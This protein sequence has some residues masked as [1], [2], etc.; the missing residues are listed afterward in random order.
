MLIN[1]VRIY[2]FQTEEQRLKVLQLILKNEPTADNVEIATLAKHTEGFSGSDLQE[3]CRNASIYRIR[4]YL[5][6]QYVSDLFIERKSN[7]PMISMNNLELRI[8]KVKDALHQFPLFNLGIQTSTRIVKK[9]NMTK[10]FMTLYDP[11][12]WKICLSHSER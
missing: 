5:Y 10:S 7:L 2:L 6:S 8:L 9:K 1:E 3:L 4:D 11:S 12:Q